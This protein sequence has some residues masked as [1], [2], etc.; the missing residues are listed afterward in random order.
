[1]KETDVPA[2]AS[3]PRVLLRSEDSD[4]HLSVIETAPA[5]GVAPPLHSHDFDETFYIM[6]GE[7]TFRLRDEY[8]KL[9]AGQVA[10]AP[11]GVPHTYANLS[12]VPA[13][14]LII[15]TPAGFERY[16]ARIAAE[17]QGV[18]PP[19]WARQA[20]PEVTTL[21]PQIDPTAAG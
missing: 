14:Q 19:D 8:F 5:P 21:G 16:F 15:C 11:R 3:W 1:M 10:F 13:R 18:E 7:L 12:G 6:E 20:L 17:R 9:T 4:N 2:Q